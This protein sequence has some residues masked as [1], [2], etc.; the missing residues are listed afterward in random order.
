MSF[1]VPELFKVSVKFVFEPLL[2]MLSSS[3]IK[4][5]GELPSK[6]TRRKRN[7]GN[8]IKLPDDPEKKT[9]VFHCWPITAEEYFDC[10]LPSKK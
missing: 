4:T 2:Y 5:L 7:R 6:L 1:I 9:V 3:C 10:L 8:N